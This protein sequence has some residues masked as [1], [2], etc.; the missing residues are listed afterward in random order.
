MSVN[1]DLTATDSGAT[2]TIESVKGS[3]DDLSGSSVSASDAVGSF[4][5]SLSAASRVGDSALL[6]VDRMQISQD[7]LTNA[8]IRQELAQ[9]RLTDAVDKYGAGSQQA[10]RAQQELQIATDNVTTAQTRRE[11]RRISTALVTIPRMISG[12]RS[13]SEQFAAN[14]VDAEG[15]T[16]SIEAL[17]SAQLANIA[18]ATLGVGVP[19]ALAALA[20]AQ[21][22]NVGGGQTTNLYGNVSINGADVSNVGA[23]TSQ[24][25]LSARP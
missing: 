6:A 14:T 18:V 20:L 7:G 10:M 11:E 12:L 24:F 1:V 8:Q 19:I 9:T 13:L 5:G 4:S 23:T 3:V 16:V 17:T 22:A 21:S 15:E 25:A 2:S